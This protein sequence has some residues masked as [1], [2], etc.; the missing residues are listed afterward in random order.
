[1]FPLNEVIENGSWLRV[2]TT[3]YEGEIVFQFRP[4]SFSK[5]DLR[6]IDGLEKLETFD[7]NANVFL[8]KFDVVNLSKKNK[9]SGE[10]IG[11]YIKL[12]DE[13]S[14]VFSFTKDSYLTMDSNFSK[15]SGIYHFMSSTLPPKITK[16]GALAYELADF[17]QLFFDVSSG[18]IRL[19]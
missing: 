10:D 2:D 5:I 8:L 16:K 13:D 15:T 4:T 1:M 9:I 18:T 7:V 3:N 19:A 11:N 14:C 17:D 6:E 12:L